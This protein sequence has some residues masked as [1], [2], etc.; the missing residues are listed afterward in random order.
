M[1]FIAPRFQMG[2]AGKP[3]IH[4]YP[5]GVGLFTTKDSA[6]HWCVKQRGQQYAALPCCSDLQD[7]NVFRLPSLGAALHF[8]AD[9]LAFLQRTEAVRL[10]SREMN[11]YI[12]AVLP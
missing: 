5:A 3:N 4:A 1:F 6:D 9:R 8:E 7:L 12:F 11:E 2:P 10:D